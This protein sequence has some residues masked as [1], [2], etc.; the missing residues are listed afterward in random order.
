MV[1]FSICNTR[2][3]VLRTAA[4]TSIGWTSAIGMSPIEPR[5]SERRYSLRLAV[6]GAQALAPSR[7]RL[8]QYSLATAV[9]VEADAIS[10]RIL[11]RRFS[12][13]GS[14]P[15]ETSSRA[16]SRRRRASARPTTE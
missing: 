12:I 8:A 7:L 11:S 9:N 2:G 15:S 6:A 16:A 3:T 4:K 14:R 10:A 1:A 13:E 5:S